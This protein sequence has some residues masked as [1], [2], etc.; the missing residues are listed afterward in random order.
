MATL[1]ANG[2]SRAHAYPASF[3][4]CDR[5]DPKTRGETRRLQIRARHV[6][7]LRARARAWLRWHEEG[8][9]SRKGDGS[10][11]HQ[12]NWM[13]CT[14]QAETGLVLV[15]P[16]SGGHLLLPDRKGSG[17]VA[18][19]P[20]P[21]LS[22]RR[23]DGRGARCWV[24]ALAWPLARRRRDFPNWPLARL[25]FS[26]RWRRVDMWTPGPLPRTPPPQAQPKLLAGD[27]PGKGGRCSRP[28]RIENNTVTPLLLPH[29]LRKE[30]A[31]QQCLPAC[32]EILGQTKPTDFHPNLH[33]TLFSRPS[34][35]YYVE[36]P[37][38]QGAP[39]RKRSGL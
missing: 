28:G 25:C 7:V 9:R 6:S 18:G 8:N 38:H 30:S 10:M 1:H 39:G 15:W 35:P 34:S 19:A 3:D 21:A 17:P 12:M 23:Y 31:L 11:S 20:S 16:R 22:L 26:A 32:L 24:L 5:R 33:T 27:K 36:E 2:P 4:W 37:P 29:A 13:E 14:R